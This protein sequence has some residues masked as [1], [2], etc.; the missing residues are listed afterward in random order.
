MEEASQVRRA[1]REAVRDVNPEQFHHAVEDIIESGEMAPG[2]LVVLCARAAEESVS[3]EVVAERAA[4]TQLIYEG[5]RLTRALAHEVPWEAGE[6]GDID[7]L[8]ADVLVARGFYLLARTEAATS[9]VETVRNFGR[10]QT[11]R[12]DGE[13]FDYRLEADVFE[14]AA[15]AGMTAVGTHPSAECREFV[16]DLARSVEDTPPEP[17][18]VFD[19]SVRESLRMLSST[20]AE[21]VGESVRPSATDP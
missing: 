18:R 17:E 20:P 3:F 12:S 5:L 8:A 14:L 7:V 1:A 6:D 16:A 19:T 11:R 13:L 9:A 10:D 2:V 21:S 4:G 15:A